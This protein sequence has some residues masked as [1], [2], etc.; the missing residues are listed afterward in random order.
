MRR[1]GNQDSMPNAFQFEDHKNLRMEKIE[2][3]WFLAEQ[4]ERAKILLEEFLL[5]YLLEDV[6][7]IALKIEHARNPNELASYI[8][9]LLK[10]EDGKFSIIGEEME[11]I[12]TRLMRSLYP[13]SYFS[14][15]GSS[16]IEQFEYFKQHSDH[17]VDNVDL[18]KEELRWAKMGDANRPGSWL[19]RDRQSQE[20]G[21]HP[22]EEIVQIYNQAQGERIDEILEEKRNR[23]KKYIPF[24]TVLGVVGGIAAAVAGAVLMD[25]VVDIEAPRSLERGT[26]SLHSDL[27]EA[28]QSGLDNVGGQK[29]TL[30]WA[31][32]FRDKTHLEM[33]TI[34]E[35]KNAA[36]IQLKSDAQY[37]DRIVVGN[38]HFRVKDGYLALPG[39]EG[40]QLVQV[41]LAEAGSGKLLSEDRDF[42]IVRD[43]NKGLYGIR[44]ISDINDV[45]VSYSVDGTELKSKKTSKFR[46]A[47][48]N[49]ERGKVFKI[50]QL[51]AEAG[52]VDVSE[53]IQEKL[54]EGR[55]SLE[56]VRRIIAN[57][58]YYT[59]ARAPEVKTFSQEQLIGNP[60]LLF[61]S[62]L[63]GS[64]LFCECDVSN[65]ANY[66]F[67]KLFYGEDSAI[68]PQMR[69]AYVVDGMEVFFEAH[70]Y[71]EARLK[72]TGETHVYDSTSQKG[73]NSEQKKRMRERDSLFRNYFS[74]SVIKVSDIDE[75]VSQHLKSGLASA[76][77]KRKAQGSGES[78]RRP[79]SRRDHGRSGGRRVKVGRSAEH[80]TKKGEPVNRVKKKEK[81]HD[82]RGLWAKED[83]GVVATTAHST[84]ALFAPVHSNPTLEILNDAKSTVHDMELRAEASRREIEWKKKHRSAIV[85]MHRRM[86]DF[87]EARQTHE[88]NEQERNARVNRRARSLSQMTPEVQEIARITAALRRYVES[89]EL[90]LD[91]LEEK[92]YPLA[93]D[94]DEIHNVEELFFKIQKDLEEA[95]KLVGA[96]AKYEEATKTEYS[97][98]RGNA[99]LAN[100]DKHAAEKARA[101][102]KSKWLRL[103]AQKGHSEHFD[104]HFIAFFSRETREVL[105]AF[106]FDTNAR[107]RGE[108]LSFRKSNSHKSSMNN[109]PSR[110]NSQPT[111]QSNSQSAPESATQ[112][113]SQANSDGGYCGKHR[114]AIGA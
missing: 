106:L 94:R 19:H 66:L 101:L 38:G 114:L 56:D 36:V 69:S 74:N 51:M 6:S 76:E 85:E 12:R 108:D 4:N 35:L 72:S 20:R 71:A 2:P 10:W 13:S 49:L 46:E 26:S 87:V 59:N 67:M 102:E 30:F 100:V 112:P 1:Q 44:F 91:W 86:G 57:E 24:K 88:E 55:I 21:A 40:D 90:S 62:Y 17:G 80:A 39:S 78:E 23:F 16:P 63:E 61:H 53:K 99:M 93:V 98:K 96:Q 82:V 22:I 5:E 7:N 50:S 75:L 15:N 70:G 104:P 42:E 64:A 31:H 29:E 14:T 113:A 27:R 60:Y 110:T 33:A 79:A 8:D 11:E 9:N 28:W 37:G 43:A 77:N 45:A 105:N 52:L 34:E 25:R 47:T 41:K 68:S 111:S 54:I 89:D 81:F 73:L 97:S 48:E 18:S 3:G 83:S 95:R 92:L 65:M 109:P 58:S 103:F 32:G 84:S 107:P